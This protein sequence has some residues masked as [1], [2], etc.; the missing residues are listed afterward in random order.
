MDASFDWVAFMRALAISLGIGLLTNL[1]SHLMLPSGRKKLSIMGMAL[2][3]ISLALIFTPCIF[4]LWPSLAVVPSLDHL[5]Q[6]QAEEVLVSAKLSS[7]ARPQYADGVQT[8]LVI[9][10]SQSLRPGLQVRPGTVVSFGV[11]VQEKLVPTA[12]P[13]D[14]LNISLFQPQA[15]ASVRC[16]RSADGTY[17]VT[18]TGAST[19][20]SA[21]DLRLLLWIK[22]VSPPADVPGW[23][24]QRA[25]VGGI[26]MVEPDGSWSGVAQIGNAQWP[27][28]EGDVVDL[29]IS[30]VEKQTAEQLMAEGGVVVRDQPLG[31]KSTTASQVALTLK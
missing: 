19:G 22:P 16:V 15:G 18:V 9:P 10:N 25:P 23:Y 20:V 1:I 8:G 27:P 17:R 29:A 13:S 2:I 7:D 3:V 28:H 30:V 6:A 14:T 11:S 31:I 24:L 12:A 26:S 4:Y 21:G 5:S